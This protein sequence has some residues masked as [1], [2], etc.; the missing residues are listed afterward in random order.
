MEERDILLY[1][2]AAFNCLLILVIGCILAYL[3]LDR[4]LALPSDFYS[5]DQ[6]SACEEADAAAAS[7]S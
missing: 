5:A 6:D 1:T 2:S 7:H 4:R 3:V